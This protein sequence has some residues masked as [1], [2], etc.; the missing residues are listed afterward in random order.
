[1][2]ANTWAP[3]TWRERTAAQQP[4]WPDEAALDRSLKL[5][6][7]MPPLVFAGEARDLTGALAQVAGGRAFLLQAGDCAESFDA[8]TADGIRDR[9][10]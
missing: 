4:E 1:M 2:S 8:F 7:T 10:Q 5:L 3:G 9:L 6:S